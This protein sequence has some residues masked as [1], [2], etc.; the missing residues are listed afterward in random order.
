M[1]F[2]LENTAVREVNADCP[3]L[4]GAFE[5]EG[6]EAFFVT[7]FALPEKADGNCTLRFDSVRTLRITKDKTT[8]ETTTDCLE[9]V[10]EAGNGIFVEIIK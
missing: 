2:S 8:W 7:H 9:V 4:V 3:V 6:G 1:D 10:L 5:K